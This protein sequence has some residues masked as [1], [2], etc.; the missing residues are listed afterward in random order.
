MTDKLCVVGSDKIKSEIFGVAFF[1]ILEVIVETPTTEHCN[2]NNNN[3][4][5]KK[6]KIHRIEQL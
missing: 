3:K 2:C 1:F 5:Y 4:Q 6:R